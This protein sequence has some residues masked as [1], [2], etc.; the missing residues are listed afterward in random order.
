MILNIRD[1]HWG[2]LFLFFMLGFKGLN[3][4]LGEIPAVFSTPSTWKL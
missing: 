2:E 3:R 1:I 4:F